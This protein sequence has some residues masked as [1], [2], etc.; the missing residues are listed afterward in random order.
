MSNL[1]TINALFFIFILFYYYLI[2]INNFSY[3]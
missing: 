1:F 2:F 3:L